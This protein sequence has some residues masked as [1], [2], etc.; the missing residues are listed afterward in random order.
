[1]MK[2]GKYDV[3]CEVCRK[4]VSRQKD[5]NIYLCK[6]CAKEVADLANNPFRMA[7][8]LIKTSGHL[9]NPSA[10]PL[11]INATDEEIN[12]EVNRER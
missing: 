10:E 5:V 1:M 3:F 8:G 12:A 7:L 4:Q 6:R 2:K 9:E 11:D